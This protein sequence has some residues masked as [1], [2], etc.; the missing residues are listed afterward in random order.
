MGNLHTPISWIGSK[1]SVAKELMGFFPIKYKTYIEPFFGSGAV[2]FEK[3]PS[4]IEIINDA[5]P[6][7][8]QFFNYLKTTDKLKLESF[9]VAN[10]QDFDYFKGM[11]DGN[12]YNML[13]EEDKA[14]LF[15]TLICFS[16]GAG[17]KQYA[18]SISRQKV[19]RE[20]DIQPYRKRLENTIIENKDVRDIIQ[21]YDA[22][23]AFFYFDPPYIVADK[24]S[25]Y[26]Y[27]IGP[28]TF[29]RAVENIKGKVLISYESQIGYFSVKKHFE[30]LGYNVIPFNFMYV[31]DNKKGSSNKS[32]QIGR[33]I[34]I[35]NYPISKIS[36]WGGID[37]E[38]T[39]KE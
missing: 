36:E 6:K 32:R 17:M 10:N 31:I 14:R 7:V 35:A 13:S 21:K 29:I 16:Y 39:K 34:L 4:E 18:E 30:D 23:D 5:N 11:Y 19:I 25:Y 15:Y 20:F 9:A 26:E 24:K 37:E 3:A 12:D 2:Y 38:T 27:T 22:S 1:R 33:E 8:M 28:N